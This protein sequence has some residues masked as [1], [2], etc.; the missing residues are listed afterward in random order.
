MF[1][2]LSYIYCWIIMREIRQNTDFNDR[3]L[4]PLWFSMFDLFCYPRLLWCTWS[5]WNW[6]KTGNFCKCLG[7]S[8]HFQKPLICKW[9]KRET[10]YTKAFIQEQNENERNETEKVSVRTTREVHWD[11][12]LFSQTNAFRIQFRSI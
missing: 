11:R 9:Q 4:A 6:T 8:K 3:L 1:P 2:F 7:K 5:G 10:S 12:R